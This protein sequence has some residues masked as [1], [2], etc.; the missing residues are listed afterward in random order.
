MGA[1][2]NKKDKTITKLESFKIPNTWWSRPYEYYFASKFLDKKD[3]VLDAGCGF[4]HPF[5]FY[6]SK[7]V[8]KLFAL[9]I[10]ERLN[11][12]SSTNKLQIIN[13]DILN[14]KNYVPE[15]YFDKIFFISIL[16]K[17]QFEAIRILREVS[18]VLKSDG[19]IIVTVDFPDLKPNYLI[20]IVKRS[21]LKFA[22]TPN[23]KQSENDIISKNGNIKCYNAILQKL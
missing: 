20:E 23:Y 6:A 17:V 15:E 12:I 13:D 4:Q 5:K 19:K 16:S 11:S 2:F 9:D 7:R 1:F 21:G 22:L 14:I 8:K 10:D 18:K 3:I